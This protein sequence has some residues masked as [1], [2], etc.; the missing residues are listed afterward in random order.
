MM[1]HKLLIFLTVYICSVHS[2]PL[3]YPKAL[4]QCANL[5]NQGQD[6]SNDL[7]YFLEQGRFPAGKENLKCIFQCIANATEIVDSNFI[8]TADRLKGLVE[9][10]KEIPSLKL[11]AIDAVVKNCIPP[12]DRS[13]P[14]IIAY[15][16]V[17][18]VTDVRKAMKKGP[19]V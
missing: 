13:S 6:F 3:S 12:K 11:F 2:E 7:N 8:P 9:R 19:K 14:C 10:N 5:Y 1:S 4:T 18:C 17:K 15:D 16:F